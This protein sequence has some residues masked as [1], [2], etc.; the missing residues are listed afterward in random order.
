MRTALSN[1]N[2][3]LVAQHPDYVCRI[4]AVEGDVGRGHLG[5]FQDVETQVP[6]GFGI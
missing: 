3:D 5:R 6:A 2:S 4:T 1:L